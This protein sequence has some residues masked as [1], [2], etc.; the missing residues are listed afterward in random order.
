MRHR[1]RGDAQRGGL[2]GNSMPERDSATPA[3][4]NTAYFIIYSLCCCY[5][6]AVILQMHARWLRALPESLTRVSSSGIH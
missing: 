1:V 4:L 6:F 3:R 5:V 2:S